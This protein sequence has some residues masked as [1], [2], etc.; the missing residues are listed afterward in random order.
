MRR[1][2]KVYRQRPEGLHN[3]NIS[4]RKV[5]FLLLICIFAAAFLIW[6]RL[7]GPGIPCLFHLVT[8]LDCPGC[9]VTRMILAVSRMD[10]KTAMR[11]NP[12]L[13]VTFPC[14]ALLLTHYAH[15]WLK[16]GKISKKAEACA[17]LYCVGL[18][19]FGI[20]RNLI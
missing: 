4:S 11:A 20:F 3:E 12:F 19:L 17:A 13:F 6:L 15:R 16:N 1:A 8:G 7:G 14:P 9:G 5:I 2:G 18:V 10:F